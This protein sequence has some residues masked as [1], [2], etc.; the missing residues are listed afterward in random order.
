[1]KNYNAWF[2]N[3]SLDPNIDSYGD[4]YWQ[5]L[6][7]KK[8]EPDTMVFLE[9]NIDSTTDFIDIGAATGGM[10]IIAANFGA[11][12]VAFEPVPRVFNIAQKHIEN[13]PNIAPKIELQNKAISNKPGVLTLG[14]NSNPEVLS[15]ISDEPPSNP[16]GVE[17]IEIA[18]LSMV[19]EQHHDPSRKLILK[20][21]IE[22]AEWQL[23][24]DRL[25]LQ[26]LQDRN[27]LVLLAIHPGFTKPFRR[28]PLGITYISKKIWQVKNLI[29]A[30]IFFSRLFKYAKLT[31]T[32][33]DPIKSP[34]KCV[35]LM[36]GGYFEFILRFEKTK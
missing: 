29:V 26:L 8:Y 25:L 2:G 28:G 12:V 7:D 23:L 10:S 31:R 24:S 5:N 22:G 27:A 13:N 17:Y 14:K 15:S 30:Y 6:S 35:L 36:F 19:V 1:M 3:F 4:S 11:R 9:N 18:S 21:D 34:K 16:T 20:I 32:N 33:L